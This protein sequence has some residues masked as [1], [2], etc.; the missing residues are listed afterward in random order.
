[1]GEGVLR[2][3]LCQHCGIFPKMHIVS[4]QIEDVFIGV[5]R[6][7]H[8]RSV[9]PSFLAIAHMAPWMGFMASEIVIL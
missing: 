9:W 8:E 5:H 3:L 6:K 2:V 4:I 1:M 7:L